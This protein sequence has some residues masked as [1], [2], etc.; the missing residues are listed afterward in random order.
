MLLATG[1]LTWDDC[2]DYTPAWDTLLWFSILVSMCNA[3]SAS[4]LV[5]QFAQM[6]GAA[7]AQAKLNWM[8]SFALLHSAF[9]WSHCEC[10]L[11]R[12]CVCVRVCILCLCA[13]SP[14]HLTG[15]PLMQPDGRSCMEAHLGEVLR[16]V[17]AAS[18][19]DSSPLVCCRPACLAWPK[20][21]TCDS[22]SGSCTL[23]T[24]SHPKWGMWGRC[25]ALSWL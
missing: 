9:F 19:R 3:L 23:Q 17:R 1:T 6:V 22:L 8:A 5:A 11:S 20:Q 18:I 12:V 15:R 24:C 16:P 13:C 10:D 4:G 21:G 25:M 2:L 14:S 7:L